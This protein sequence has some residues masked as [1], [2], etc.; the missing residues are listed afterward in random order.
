MTEPALAALLDTLQRISKNRLPGGSSR[1][2]VQTGTRPLLFVDNLDR[3]L[4]HPSNLPKTCNLE[5]FHSQTVTTF[6][7]RAL[8]KQF[9]GPI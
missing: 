2:Q 9:N 6:T 8:K 1:R 7:K 3:P 5:K 4:K